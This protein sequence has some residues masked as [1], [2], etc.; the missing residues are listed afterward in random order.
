MDTWTIPDP[1]H[2][3]H[4][5]EL[6][7]ARSVI[8]HALCVYS[9]TGVSNGDDHTELWFDRVWLLEIKVKKRTPLG[10]IEWGE[11]HW[12]LSMTCTWIKIPV[13]HR[14]SQKRWRYFS[15]V[16]FV[17]CT[18]TKDCLFRGISMWCVQ[19]CLFVTMATQLVTRYGEFNLAYIDGPLQFNTQ[20]HHLLTLVCKNK[21][22]ESLVCY[23]HTYTTP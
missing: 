1:Q 16:L 20:T 6:L 4:Y 17:W 12:N 21:T 8:I 18:K 10:F 9:F 19:D 11:F 13:G 3:D 15:M 7:I 2:R 5:D 23:N 22:I 14:I